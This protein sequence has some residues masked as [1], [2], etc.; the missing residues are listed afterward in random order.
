MLTSIL[1]E[2]VLK[3]SFQVPFGFGVV[4]FEGGGV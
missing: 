4:Y 1:T 2:R 3:K